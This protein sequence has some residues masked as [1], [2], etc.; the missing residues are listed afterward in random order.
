MIF[1]AQIIGGFAI[2]LW[3]VGLQV[4]NRKNVLLFQ[5]AANFLY[6]LEYFMLGAISA[7]LMNLFSTLRCLF[8]A[9]V[10]DKKAR[11][12]SILFVVVIL[13]IFV[14][15]Y[16]GVLSLIPII[17]TII[18]TISSSKSD[19]KWNRLCVLVTAFIWIYYNYKVGAYITI[20]G[21]VMEIVS[22]TIA[23]VRFK[24]K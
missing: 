20:L 8:F 15:I 4:K 23:L 17:I 2:S 13:F 10:D 5:C 16:D 21:N 1:C 24:N 22:G 7:S 3:V 19:A 12:F 18:Y 14:F 9:K 6:F 11:L